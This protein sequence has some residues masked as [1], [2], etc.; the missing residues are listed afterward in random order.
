[1]LPAGMDIAD[2]NNPCSG[3][4][5][6]IRDK[7]TATSCR[8]KPR[9]D[10]MIMNFIFMVN[11]N[12]LTNRPQA[13]LAWAESSPNPYFFIR[14]YTCRSLMPMICA[15]VARCPACFSSNIFR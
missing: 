15:T 13:F 14:R 7:I 11:H 6:N 12:R 4:S 8:G 3:A 2:A 9:M 10:L 5:A 1:M